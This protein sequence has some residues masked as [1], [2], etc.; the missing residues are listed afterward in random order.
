V[1]PPLEPQDG[2]PT[3]AFD[4]SKIREVKPQELA[5]RF[6]FGAGVSIVASVVSTLAGPFWGGTFLAFPAVLAAGLTLTEREEGTEAALH[7]QRGALLGGFGMVAFAVVAAIGFG[8]LP[9]AVA[10]GAAI[11]AWSVTAVGVYLAVA[12][13]RRRH[14]GQCDDRL[15]TSA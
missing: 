5:I 2:N 6:V 7:I 3:A 11:A 10:L 13:W 4:F 9:L 12:S 15:T 8:R 1:T 14:R